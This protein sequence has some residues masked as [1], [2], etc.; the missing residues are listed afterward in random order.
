MSL[1]RSLVLSIVLLS[2]SSCGFEPVYGNRQGNPVVNSAMLG[3]V[4]VGPISGRDGQILKIA[5]E[6]YLNPASAQKANPPYRLDATLV[7]TII[8]GVV[9][10][11]ASIERYSVAIES[12]F[13]LIDAGSGRSVYSGTA[14]RFGSYSRSKSDFSTFVAET[15]VTKQTI[16]ELAADIVTRISALSISRSSSM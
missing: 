7:K 10:S 4:S 8:P 1:L 3:N 12:K 6:D 14:K 5:L 15:D 2:L 13:S 9:G 11:D 16:E